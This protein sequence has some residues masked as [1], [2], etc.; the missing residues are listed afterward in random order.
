MNYHVKTSP[1]QLESPHLLSAVPRNLVLENSVELELS[2]KGISV[3]IVLLHP[4]FSSISPYLLQD[5]LS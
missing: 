1:T 4:S 3:R 5:L 2:L